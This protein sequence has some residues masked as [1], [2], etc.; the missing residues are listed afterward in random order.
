MS[1]SK[2]TI[3]EQSPEKI[4]VIIENPK[5]THNKYEYKEDL[6]E[7]AL[8]RVL[9]SAVFFPAEYG[10][11]PETLSPDGDNLDILVLISE[12]TFPGCILSCRPV[13]SLNMEDE[14]GEDSKI[15]AVAVDD[16][17]YKNINSL[18]DIDE[19]TKKEIENFFHIYKELEDKFVNVR[20]WSGKNE[21]YDLIKAS[22]KRFLEK[23]S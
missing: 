6:G 10:L 17:R 5:G 16:P 12:P 15:I 19:H 20:G 4:N 22:Q 7:I 14:G 21:A 23:T 13:G 18:D 3:G 1:F 8:D 11:I 2:I 9:H